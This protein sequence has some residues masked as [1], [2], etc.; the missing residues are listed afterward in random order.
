MW[1]NHSVF[2][3]NLCVTNPR[4]NIQNALHRQIDRHGRLRLYVRQVDRSR[5]HAVDS[6]YYQA[7]RD[8]IGPL[9]VHDRDC[10]GC[11][12]SKLR[13]DVIS[14]NVSI[15]VELLALEFTIDNE[16]STKYD[17]STVCL[18]KRLTFGLL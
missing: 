6:A 7:K 18:Q 13:C 14:A 8:D 5:A 17:T 3:P 12:N 2:S 4:L 16:V 1:K 10:S 11:S 9:T 15:V